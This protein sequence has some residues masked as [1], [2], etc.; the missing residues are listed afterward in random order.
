[1]HIRKLI[2]F[3]LAW[4]FLLFVFLFLS[5]RVL[6][7]QKNFLGGGL[8]NYL[9]TPY[10]W[11]WSNFDGEHY[12]N[13]AQHGYGYLEQAF[14][15][16]YPLLIRLFGVILGGEFVYYNLAALFISNSS[17]FIGLIGL[18]KLIRLD[19]SDKVANIALLLFL[20]FPTSFYFGSVYTESLFFVLVVWSFYF[21]R[22]RNWWLAGILG[23]IAS[24]TRFLGVFLLPSL[25]VEYLLKGKNRNLK[26][27]LPILIIP[28]GL[29][30]F[31]Y[32]LY[33]TE[34]DPLKFIHVLP[35]FG[36]QRQIIPV[37]LPQVF[38]RYFFKILPNINYNYFPVVFTT[39]LEVLVAIMFLV[40]VIVL[41]WKE[42]LSYA[43][44]S[45]SSYLIPTLSGSFSSLPR[46]VITIFPA[47]IIAS[48][49]LN[50]SP[51]WLKIVLFLILFF[52]LGT[53]TSLFVRA[54]WVS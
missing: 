52:M 8:G 11:A 37:V 3:F 21:A 47:F 10:F 6:P 42:R 14:F 20:L 28:S 18:I 45:L 16:L 43:V 12:L 9:K 51:I 35:G 41:F 34:K 30:G 19:Y 15:P 25:L 24:G 53:A 54:Y 17:F 38:Y 39:I 50:K 44:F 48:V 2:I 27:I 13:I 23:A 31:M 46:Y 5:I 40:L 36:E 33:L 22:K 32:F 26:N 1:M 7:L 49:Y 29:V 4:R